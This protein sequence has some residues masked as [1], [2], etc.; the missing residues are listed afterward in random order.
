MRN[1]PSTHPRDMAMRAALRD[2]ASLAAIVSGEFR[3]TYVGPERAEYVR[4]LGEYVSSLG[5]RLE[6]GPA[7]LVA[8]FEGR[9]VAIQLGWGSGPR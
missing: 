8:E 7:G 9:T 3:S 1:E 5:G 6:E 4:L 2:I